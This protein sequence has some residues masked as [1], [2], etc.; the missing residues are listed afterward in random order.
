MDGLFYGRRSLTFINISSFNLQN[1][2]SLIHM[3]A[4]CISL[5]SF[6][7]SNTVFNTSKVAQMK[8]I[9]YECHSL[10]SIYFPKTF[11]T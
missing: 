4:Y 8:N 11:E 5:K 9:F 1:T 2:L 6:D 7:I 3:F 10:T